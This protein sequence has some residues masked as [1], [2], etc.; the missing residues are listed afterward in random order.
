MKTVFSIM[1]LFKIKLNQSDNKLFN[2]NEIEFQSIKHRND[3][4]KTSFSKQCFL[5]TDLEFENF[6]CYSHA[7]SSVFTRWEKFKILIHWKTHHNFEMALQMN[8]KVIIIIIRSHGKHL[9][10]NSGSHFGSDLSN[11]YLIH[12]RIT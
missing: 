10:T 12:Y 2:K 1:V 7:R 3:M 11:D 6:F 4:S 9:I 5:S 8:K